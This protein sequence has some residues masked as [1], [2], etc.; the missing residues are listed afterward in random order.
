MLAGG[1][2]QAAS[3]T[4]VLFETGAAVGAA[5]PDSVAFGDGSVRIAHQNG[6]DS[7]ARY[8]PS[9]GLLNTFRRATSRLASFHCWE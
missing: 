5:S 7:V 6:A 8:T 2:V 3:L 9:G 1:G 4:P